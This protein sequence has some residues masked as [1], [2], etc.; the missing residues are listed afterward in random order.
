M[1]VHQF[2]KIEMVVICRPEDAEKCFKKHVQINEHIWNSL[3]LYYRKVEVCTW[4]IP[5]KHFR[6]QDY[7]AWFPAAKKFREIWSNGNASDYQNRWLKISYTNDN[8]DKKVPWWLNDTGITFRTGLAILE[9]FQTKDWKV[10]LPKV[11]AER[12]GKE[13]IE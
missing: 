9:Q 10:K 12:F 4:D 13:Y 8:W 11:L 1:R 5:S 2:E 6:Q 3:W 7:E